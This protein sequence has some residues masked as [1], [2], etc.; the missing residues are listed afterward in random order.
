MG[1]NEIVYFERPGPENT[2]AVAAAV[3][4]RC[5]ELGIRHVVAAS[6][7]GATALELHKALEG[8]GATLIAVAEHAGYAGGDAPS[9]GEAERRELERRGIKTLVAS[10][11]LSGVARSISKKFGG[12][13]PVELIA[14]VLR[15]FGTEGVKVAVEVAVMAADAGLLPT[16]SEAIA[17]GGTAE[18]ADTALVLR[19]AHMNNFFDLEVRELICKPRQRERAE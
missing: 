13:T 19:P 5:R 1:A 18:G 6:C 14:H 9:I 4:R 17:V 2:A 15:L 7:T 11:A 8:S 3:A 12:V 10:H 16:D